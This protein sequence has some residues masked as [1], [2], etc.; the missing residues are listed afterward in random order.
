MRLNVQ[1]IISEINPTKS[2]ELDMKK[3]GWNRLISTLIRAL[4]S[5][6]RK[7]DKVN[8]VRKRL[9]LENGPKSKT[10][11]D[12]HLTKLCCDFS[13]KHQC[14]D[15]EKS[16]WSVATDEEKDELMKKKMS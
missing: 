15:N 1:E 9:K 3:N 8:E 11:R 16:S 7:R 12:D 2:K 14:P 13:N 6:A 4:K 10:I 5:E